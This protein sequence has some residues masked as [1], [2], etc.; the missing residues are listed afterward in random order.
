MKFFDKVFN[1]FDNRQVNEQL[2]VDRTKREIDFKCMFKVP[3]LGLVGF[4]KREI[5]THLKT[6]V[7]CQ[8]S[9]L[10]NFEVLKKCMSDPGTSG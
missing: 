6:C 1:V 10:D 5:E 9:S 2:N 7:I 3:Y 4:P 8:N